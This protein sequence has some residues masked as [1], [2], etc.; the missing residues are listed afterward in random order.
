MKVH[1][2]KQGDFVTVETCDDEHMGEYHGRDDDFTCLKGDGEF[3][4]IP[5]SDVI[6]IRKPFVTVENPT[7]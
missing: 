6:V 4:Y 3:I 1:K 2:L 5:N 7:G